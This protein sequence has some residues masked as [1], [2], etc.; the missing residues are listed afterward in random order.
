[1]PGW[2]A[3][4]ES[5]AGMELVAELQSLQHSQDFTTNKAR[6]KTPPRSVSNW[7]RKRQLL[8]EMDLSSLEPA[9]LE[10]T[11]LSEGQHSGH[12]H[13][14]REQ[15]CIIHGLAAVPTPVRALGGSRC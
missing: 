8:Q 9:H 12:S 6:L 13:C 3:A 2:A 15:L 10:G 11:A 4:A 14:H 5:R 1:M 7:E